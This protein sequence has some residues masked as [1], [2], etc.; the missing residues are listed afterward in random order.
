MAL[1][2][3]S[4]LPLAKNF[5]RAVCGMQLPDCVFDCAHAIPVLEV[6]DCLVPDVVVVGNNPNGHHT[7]NI[8]EIPVGPIVVVRHAKVFGSE[9]VV[10]GVKNVDEHVDGSIETLPA[11]PLA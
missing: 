8:S 6:L 2:A 1:V 4:L 7:G 9:L 5:A 3:A 10:H 11:T